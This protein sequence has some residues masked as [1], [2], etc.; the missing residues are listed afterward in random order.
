MATILVVD[1]D[2]TNRQL[3]STILSYRAHKIVEAADGQEGL[4]K[5]QSER[6]HLAIVDIVMPTMDGFE[7][8]RQLRSNPAIAKTPIIFYTAGY[9]EREIRSLAHD[10]GVS[11]ILTKPAEPQVIIDTVDA[12]LGFAGLPLG[13]PAPEQFDRE[14]LRVTT[15]KLSQKVAELETVSLRLERLIEIG[16]EL[17]SEHD[18]ADLI[19][20]VSGSAGLSRS[21]ASWHRSTTLTAL[22]ILSHARR[23]RS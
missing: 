1:D 5:T 10:C 16:R 8:V 2:F 18:S 17:A 20:S 11:Y 9:Y 4:A 15:D 14:H 6:P 21:G 3:L 23:A 22:P 13:F 12:A 19:D 7:F